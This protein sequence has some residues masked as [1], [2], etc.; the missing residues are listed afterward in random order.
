MNCSSRYVIEPHR[1]IKNRVVWPVGTTR[2][3]VRFGGILR[4]VTAAERI[5]LLVGTIT[6]EIQRVPTR[7]EVRLVQLWYDAPTAEAKREMD[8]TELVAV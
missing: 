6:E 3:T 7:F 8:I 1:L 2:D 5:D 4:K